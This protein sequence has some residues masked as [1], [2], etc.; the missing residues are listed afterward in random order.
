MRDPDRIDN[1]LVRFGQIW[2]EQC[3][4]MRFGQLICNVFGQMEFDPFMLEEEQMIY[5]FERYFGLADESLDP[6]AVHKEI[7]HNDY[8]KQRSGV[9]ILDGTG[10]DNT[11]KFR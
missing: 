8:R 6:I 4:D 7:L 5:E 1:F 11:T 9:K 2:R 3:P 10:K